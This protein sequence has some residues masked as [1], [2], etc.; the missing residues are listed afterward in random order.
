M[1]VTIID[2]VGLPCIFRDVTVEIVELFP[3]VLGERVF[4]ERTFE[5]AMVLWLAVNVALIHNKGSWCITCIF[6][7]NAQFVRFAICWKPSDIG[8]TILVCTYILLP[9]RRRREDCSGVVV[10]GFTWP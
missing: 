8:W 2:V 3:W 4:K 6:E 7:E 1:G 9:W 5:N 10:G